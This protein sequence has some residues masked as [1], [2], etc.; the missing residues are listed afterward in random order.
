MHGEFCNGD[1]RGRELSIGKD[2]ATAEHRTAPAHSGMLL[3]LPIMDVKISTGSR[4]DFM[5]ELLHL[6][7]H[8]MSSAYVCFVNVHMV[9]E[10]HRNDEFCAIVN[11]A[12]V[13]CPDGAP[14]AKSIGWFFG[15][16][17]QHMAGPDTLPMLVEA[18]GRYRKR[19]FLLGSTEDVLESFVEQA[20]IRFPNAVI[21]GYESPPFRALTQEEDEALIQKINDSHADMIFVALGCPKQEKWMAAHKGKVKGCM[22]GLGYA[23]PV[24]AG[25]ASRAPRWMIDHGLEW[26][27]R[28]FSDPKR[29]FKRYVDTNSVFVRRVL[30][31]WLASRW[32]RVFLPGRRGVL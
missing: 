22:F 14:V 17:Q 26:S 10:A 5:A 28:L 16:K 19:I 30:I 23:I 9:V 32:E 2:E 13:A 31:K 24:F 21:C 7:D 29:L 8:A 1:S 12:D 11:N 18:A 27:F 20:A 4:D 6:S 3:R 25:M 15:L